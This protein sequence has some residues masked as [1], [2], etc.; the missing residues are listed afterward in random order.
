MSRWGYVTLLD[1]SLVEAHHRLPDGLAPA[2]DR[3]Q[4]AERSWWLTPNPALGGFAPSELDRWGISRGFA[5]D[6]ALAIVSELARAE[7]Q[8]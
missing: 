6:R 8:A 1:G 3:P 4:L 7:G 5:G 2:G